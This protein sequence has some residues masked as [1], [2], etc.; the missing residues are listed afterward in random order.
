VEHALGHDGVVVDARD[1]GSFAAGHIP[2]ALG[3]GLSETF[4][5]W[6]GSLVAGDSSLV[7]VLDRPEDL[8]AAVGQLRR[9]GHDRIRGYLQGGYAA[10]AESGRPVARLPMRTASQLATDL[11]AGTVRVLDVREASEWNEGHVVGAVHIPGASLAGRLGEV[12]D[13]QLAVM[14]GSGYRSTIAASVLLRAGRRDVTNVIGGMAAYRAT[15]NPVT[16]QD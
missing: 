10:W 14:C 7:L 15:G 2:G 13:G 1:P 9:T 16:A 11:A 8:D 3:I 12:P 5:T 4:G 6:V